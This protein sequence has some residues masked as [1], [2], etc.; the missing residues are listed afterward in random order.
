MLEVK[1][2]RK[3]FGELPVLKGVDVRVNKG[4]ADP[5]RPHCFAALIIWS[6][7]RRER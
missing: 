6:A 5:A 2:I 3:S 7:P 1:N 4:D